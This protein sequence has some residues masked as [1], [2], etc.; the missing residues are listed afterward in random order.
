[1]GTPGVA[2]KIAADLRK[3]HSGW[4]YKAARA[5]EQATVSDWKQW[6]E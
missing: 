3:R 2:K 6:R 1:L 5:M 4:L